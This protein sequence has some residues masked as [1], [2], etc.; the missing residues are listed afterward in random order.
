MPI[1]SLLAEWT[2]RAEAALDRALPLAAHA[3]QLDAAMRHAALGG[4][5]RLRPLLVY[6]T[7]NAFNTD[8]HERDA[9]A[10]AVE[11]IHAFSLVHDDLPAM[12]DEDLR[13]GRP[14]VHV[15]FDVATAILAGDALQALAFQVLAEAPL[16]CAM[17]M[18][19]MCGHDS[20]DNGSVRGPLP[21]FTH[22]LRRNLAGVRIGVL[23][24]FFEE[25]PMLDPQLIRASDE[26]LRVM[27]DLGAVI[28][29]A[30][31]RPIRDYCDVWTLIEAPETFSI[32]RKALEQRI[33]D[34]GAVFIERTLIACLIEAS[35]YI[36][37]QR[38][39]ARMVDEM[40][41]VWEKYD[42]LVAPGGG[43]APTL[44]P[45]LSTWPSIN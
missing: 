24:H 45:A 9:S 34:F 20:R 36:D 32:Q 19:A 28:E 13:R 1:D 12:D 38:V 27:T 31:V 35:D 2:S 18:T 44:H 21:D 3:P 16:D 5:K 14:T 41:A 37:A 43:P 26:A 10:A 7:G 17:V 6:A 33:Q 29:T 11:L 4:G 30:H 40:N 22:T 39:R 8:H 23:R 25:A 15:A 42:V